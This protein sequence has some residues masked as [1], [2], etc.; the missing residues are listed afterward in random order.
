VWNKLLFFFVV[1]LLFGVIAYA[2]KSILPGIPA[3]ILGDVTFFT[4]VWPNDA[5]R[6]L[7]SRDGADAGFWIAVVV[8]IV[9]FALSAMAV[10]QVV[11]SSPTHS[12]DG[13]RSEGRMLEL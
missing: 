12:S 4:L 3:H 5:G 10:R 6:P 2:N 13:G 8:T 11:V 9:F 7:L 1:G